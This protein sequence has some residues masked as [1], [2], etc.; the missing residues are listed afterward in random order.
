MTNEGRG[1]TGETGETERVMARGECDGMPVIVRVR[2]ME[3]AT[4]RS[5]AE[6]WFD[7]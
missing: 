7:G 6:G 4:R 5:K 3:R 1:R 2:V